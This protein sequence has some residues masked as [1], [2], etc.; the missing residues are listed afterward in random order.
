[1]LLLAEALAINSLQKSSRHGIQVTQAL[2]FS[3]PY[4]GSFAFCWFVVISNKQLLGITSL[5]GQLQ[6]WC[7]KPSVKELLEKEMTTH[8][9]VLAW[10][11]PWTEEPGRLQSMGSLR[12]G[13]D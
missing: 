7:L 9:S 2:F 4:Q 5:Q 8:S 1:M 10:S 3:L 12:V 13:Q 11:I 6:V